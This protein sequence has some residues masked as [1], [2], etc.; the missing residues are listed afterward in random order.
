MKNLFI[1][2][3]VS[4]DVFDFCI[5]NQK[6][7]IL[8][9]KNV[10]PNTKD[11]ISDFFLY[12]SEFS[13]HSLWICLEHT[14]RYGALLSSEFSRRNVTFSLINPL[15]IKYSIGLTRGKNDAV[16]AY[17]IASYAVTNQHKLKPVK[18]PTTEL[19][20]LK[21]IMSVRDGLTKIMVQ[22]KNT[23]KSLEV[24]N[25]SLSMKEQIKEIKLLIKRQEKGI[26]KTENQ[27]TDII[28]GNVELKDS[29]TRICKVIG[30]GP[31][32]AIK[33]ISE[34]ENFTK[35]TSGR[36]FSC[37]CGLVPFEY[38]SGSS[39]RGRAKTSKISNKNLKGILYKAA[40]SAIQHDPQLKTYY[41]RKVN[42]GKHKLSVLNAV[43]NKLVLRIFAVAKRNEPFVK[44]YA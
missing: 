7:Q 28:Q 33:C 41:G 14:G 27:M 13:Y 6:H 25:E 35:F 20:K 11:G 30:V 18:L 44:F 17:R 15:E 37:H 34:T 23:L 38:R 12:L 43:A 39:V 40:G 19:Q 3:D 32:T 22:L 26:A 29:Y 21:A 24:L 8:S 31:I 10:L 9:S 1:G 2:I 16:D 36:S 4:K 42:E 5:L